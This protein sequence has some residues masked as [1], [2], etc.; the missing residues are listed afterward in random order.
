MITFEIQFVEQDG[1]KHAYLLDHRI[2]KRDQQQPISAVLFQ[3][4][5]QELERIGLNLSRQKIWA[6]AEQL[7]EKST[8]SLSLESQK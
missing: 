3:I 6:L 7:E 5:S 8:A 2:V 1:C 4:I